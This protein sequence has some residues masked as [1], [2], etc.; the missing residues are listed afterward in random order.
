MEDGE[1]IVVGVSGGP[2][3]VCLLHVLKR[4][5]PLMKLR[6]HAVHVNHMLRGEEAEEDERYAS[7][8]CGKLEV[9]LSVFRIDIGKLAAQKGISLEEAGREARY[10]EFQNVAQREGASRIAVAHNKND[11]VETVIMHIMRGSG[12]DGLKG[13]DYRRGIVIRPLLDADR[14]EIERYCADHS[15][16]PRT[17]SSNLEGAFLRN[18]VRL[19]LIPLIKD[20]WG[21]DSGDKLCGMAEKLRSEVDFLNSYSGERLSECLACGED[22]VALDSGKLSDLHPAIARRVVR[23]AIGILNP[24]LKGIEGA[25]VDAS[26][27]LAV[28]GRSGSLL[29]LPGGLR[30]K[31]TYGKTVITYKPDR[32]K[33][34]AF[35]ARLS[36]PGETQLT[37]G[38]LARASIEKKSSSIEHYK[39]IGYNSLVQF[40][41]YDRTG[42]G[43]NIRN[44]R[45]G[46]VFK[47]VGSNGTKKLKEYFIDEKIPRSERDSIPLMAKDGEILWIIGYKISDKFKVTENTKN[48]LKLELLYPGCG[49][50]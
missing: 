41:D 36:I 46:D 40:F 34:E 18:R 48:V 22:E 39:G 5:S 38:L 43:I 32:E 27:K 1:G 13:M 11:Q 9:P 23:L 45:N 37:G 49:G 8:I 50:R 2:D 31:K 28:S 4:L 6:L 24:G 44:R 10:G 20:I 30:V 33:K 42:G 47:P 29:H 21:P 35:D 3:S 12:S 17:D 7:E 16:S 19:E 26:V 14:S 25:H 15:L